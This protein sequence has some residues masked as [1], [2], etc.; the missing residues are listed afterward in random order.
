MG[1]AYA[2]SSSFAI[3]QAG[4]LTPK[5]LATHP[6]P[7][8]SARIHLKSAQRDLDCGITVIRTK[9]AYHFSVFAIVMTDCRLHLAPFSFISA[10]T[11]LIGPVALDKNDG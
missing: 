3:F 9:G 2:Q 10:V 11:V 7:T 4:H 6:S 5:L 1:Q 8:E